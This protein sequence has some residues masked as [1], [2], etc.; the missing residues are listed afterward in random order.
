[1]LLKR[2]KMALLPLIVCLAVGAGLFVS[3]QNFT[4]DHAQYD[5]IEMYLPGLEYDVIDASPRTNVLNTIQS[6]YLSGA[7]YVNGSMYDLSKSSYGCVGKAC[8]YIMTPIWSGALPRKFE[9]VDPTTGDIV[10][11]DSKRKVV[12]RSDYCVSTRDNKVYCSYGGNE[13]WRLVKANIN[14]H[15]LTWR[16]YVSDFSGRVFKL[17]GVQE[18]TLVTTV[19][20][21]LQN[22]VVVDTLNA[23]YLNKLR[24]CS[25][26][27]NGDYYCT[28]LFGYSFSRTN[29]A[30]TSDKISVSS[31]D[32]R[33]GA[34][35]V[36]S[37][38]CAQGMTGNLDQGATS[39]MILVTCT[40]AILE[41]ARITAST[42]SGSVY[43][44]SMASSVPAKSYSDSR[45]QFVLG[46]SA[47]ATSPGPVAPAFD[48]EADPAHQ[49][50]LAYQSGFGREPNGGE[51]G[52]WSGAYNR[53]SMRLTDL[54]SV[55]AGG[56]KSALRT[57]TSTRPLIVR[58]AYL[59][60]FQ[61]EPQPSEYTVWDNS[62]R[63]E[64]SIYETMIKAMIGATPEEIVNRAYLEGFGRKPTYAEA[65]YWVGQYNLRQ[66]TP[67]NGVNL[68]VDA[69]RSAMQSDY[70]TQRDVI[71]RAY[72][73]GFNRIPRD[74]E[75]QVWQNAISARQAIYRDL[76]AAMGK[77]I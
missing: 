14:P 74:D 2:S 67:T 36:A 3:F 55:V 15:T 70:R 61:R 40:G 57:E 8:S 7:F 60:G 6:G 69:I 50:R 56:I 77:P 46:S 34:V 73:A 48:P 33:S 66:L 76:L 54:R 5:Y 53:D 32:E 4:S 16:N 27:S 21:Q 25:L 26:N 62:L 44:V 18:P 9:F 75:Y 65:A 19:P 22:P 1:V 43:K 38:I 63:Y 24:I 31:I 72:L 10:Y 49:I 42:S 52:A 41:E 29:V 68:I 37:N 35:L 13:D 23:T 20:A 64:S 30:G 28:G 59:T 17:N 45:Q 47:T 71:A 51:I 12:R 58:H 39:P 11:R